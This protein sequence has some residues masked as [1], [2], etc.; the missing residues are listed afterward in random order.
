MRYRKSSRLACSVGTSGDLTIASIS[1]EFS[2]PC[3]RDLKIRLRTVA[4]NNCEVS[5]AALS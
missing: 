4:R 5:A 2:L 3:I 1:H